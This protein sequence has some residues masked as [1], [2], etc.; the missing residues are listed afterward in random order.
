MKRHKRQKFST[1]FL[2]CSAI[3][4]RINNKIH[5][6]RRPYHEILKI[7]KKESD[8]NER[9]GFG[10]SLIFYKMPQRWIYELSRL[11]KNYKK[12]IKRVAKK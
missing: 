12:G 9:R 4:K 11:D 10:P 5:P 2:K 7:L 8:E 1:Y 6:K 3:K